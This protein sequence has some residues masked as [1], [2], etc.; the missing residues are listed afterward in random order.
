[1][2]LKAKNLLDKLLCA[3]F[4]RTFFFLFFQ[5]RTQYII[6]LVAISP[7]SVSVTVYKRNPI[8][9]FTSQSG[10]LFNLRVIYY[11][12]DSKCM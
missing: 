1:M 5:K 7:I 12:V 3:I 11:L 6:T 9:L 2:C 4:V 10:L 8:Y